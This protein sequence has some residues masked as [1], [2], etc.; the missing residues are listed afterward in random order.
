MGKARVLEHPAK[1]PFERTELLRRL[2]HDD[3]CP[4]RAIRQYADHG[5]DE[6][7][8]SFP[9]ADPAEH[10]D[11]VAAG[12]AAHGPCPRAVRG[13]GKR[14]R[15]D[16]VTD[17]H[18]L[19]GQVRGRLRGRG[20]HRVHPP[21]VE[22]R[23]PAVMPLGGGGEEEDERKPQKAPQN[24]S[25]QHVDVPARV[26]DPPGTA[27]AMPK[28]LEEA[29]PR[30]AVRDVK[31]QRG[32]SNVPGQLGHDGDHACIDPGETLSQAGCD[33]LQSGRPLGISVCAHRSSQL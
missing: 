3:R 13:G 18:G 10:P 7:L 30:D 16:A 19:P 2:P 20:D 6:F 25:G 24:E 15:V 8:R 21:V 14:L 28:E 29:D 27:T 22:A 17:D 1:T 26:P 31:S 5:P 32:D 9:R 11:A 23:D 4:F 33:H 12:Q